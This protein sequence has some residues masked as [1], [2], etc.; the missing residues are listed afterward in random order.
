MLNAPIVSAGVIVVR[1]SDGSCLYL[2]L[3]AYSYWDFPKGIVEAGEC[4]LEA[5]RREVVEETTITELEFCWGNGFRDTGRYGGGKIARYFVACTK[6][7]AVHLPV[8]PELGRPE[9]HEFRWVHYRKARALLSPRVRP[10][11][12]WAHQLTGCG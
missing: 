10:I 6:Q 3:R 9:H 2:L 8:S 5:A 1:H 7:E 12:D 4:P 11:L